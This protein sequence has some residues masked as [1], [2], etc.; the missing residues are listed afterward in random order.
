[1]TD[2]KRLNDSEFDKFCV[3]VKK[4][5]NWPQHLAAKSTR[6]TYKQNKTLINTSKTIFRLS[7][8]EPHKMYTNSQETQIGYLAIIYTVFSIQNIYMYG[9]ITAM[10]YTL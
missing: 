7:E 1:M 9:Y 2:D 5:S 4:A 8:K 6:T 3:V 10:N